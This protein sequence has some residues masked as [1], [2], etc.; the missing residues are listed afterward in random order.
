M[1]DDLVGVLARFHRDILLPDMKRVVDQAVGGLRDEMHTLMDGF[2][3]R[4]D[5]LET[6]YHMLVVGLG[7]VEER[8]DRIESGLGVLSEGQQRLALRRL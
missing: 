8:L 6:E 2:A 7:R 3:Q 5:R 4:F 1:T